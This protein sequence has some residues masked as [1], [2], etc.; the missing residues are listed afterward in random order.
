MPKHF[1][2]KRPDLAAAIAEALAACKR[3]LKSAAGVR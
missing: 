2:L 1:H 3:R